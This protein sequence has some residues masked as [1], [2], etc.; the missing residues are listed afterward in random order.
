MFDSEIVSFHLY[1]IQIIYMKSFKKGQK[2]FDLFFGFWVIAWKG[3]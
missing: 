1:Q 2:W 3:L